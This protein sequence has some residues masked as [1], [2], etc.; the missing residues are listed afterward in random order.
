[1]KRCKS[2][3]EDKFVEANFY[4]AGKDG[5]YYQTFCKPCFNLRRGQP[6]KLVGWGALPRELRCAIAFGVHEGLSNLEISKILERGYPDFSY[7]KLRYYRST[8]Q[9]PP[10]P[11][12]PDIISH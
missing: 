9:V 3:G 8:G 7:H 11:L 1:M 2:C 4:R 5:S 12:E 10:H 6:R